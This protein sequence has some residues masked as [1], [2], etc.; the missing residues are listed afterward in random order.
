MLFP[1][2]NNFFMGRGDIIMKKSIMVFIAMCISCFMCI[3]ASASE[4]GFSDIPIYPIDAMNRLGS[5]SLNT[6]ENTINVSCDV[7]SNKHEGY[8]ISVYEK[9]ENAKYIVKYLGPIKI[10]DFKITGLEGNKEY[11]VLLSSAG[12]RQ[13]V[14]GKIFTSYTEVD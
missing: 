13:T 14:S 5:I 3:S 10:S 6:S 2:N 12:N 1:I 9:G 8:Y 4:F 7:I 11:Y